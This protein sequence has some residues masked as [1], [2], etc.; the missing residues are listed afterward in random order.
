MRAAQG[1][2]ARGSVATEEEEYEDDEDYSE[3]EQRRDLAA[4]RNVSALQ[5]VG[6]DPSDTSLRGCDILS[7]D[8]LKALALIA[9]RE[10]FCGPVSCGA[11]IVSNFAKIL[12][13]EIIILTV[14]HGSLTM[15]DT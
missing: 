5:A 4:I 12:V 13:K 3:E 1:E 8:V 10:R 2:S 11:V 14:V 7:P 6:L 15:P 9:L